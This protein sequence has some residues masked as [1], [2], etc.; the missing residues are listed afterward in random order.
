MYVFGKGSRT[1]FFE[2]PYIVGD[3]PARRKM[4]G[5]FLSANAKY[6]CM[7]CLYDTRDQTVAYNG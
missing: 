3:G 2:I 1:I 6:G 4:V 5:H 7:Y